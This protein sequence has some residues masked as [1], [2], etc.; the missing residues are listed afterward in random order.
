METK[1]GPGTSAV[2]GLGQSP[3]DIEAAGFVDKHPRDLRSAAIQYG[4]L[5]A[6]KSESE[7]NRVEV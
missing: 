4:L 6:C 7:P 1:W 5:A 3:P 2:G